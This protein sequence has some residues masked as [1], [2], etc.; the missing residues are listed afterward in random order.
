MVPVGFPLH[1]LGAGSISIEGR[2]SGKPM[3]RV[4]FLGLLRKYQMC[5]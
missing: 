1:S 3:G 5:V 4:G 2:C